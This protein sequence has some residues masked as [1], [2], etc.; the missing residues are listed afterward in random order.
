MLVSAATLAEVGSGF[1]F[2]TCNIICVIW[3]IIAG[4]AA[5]II[6]VSGV[7]FITAETYEK[8]NEA[9]INII[10]AVIGIIIVVIAPYTANYL[11]GGLGILPFSCG[12]L[13]TL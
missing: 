11:T 4:F 8:R 12:C 9:K 1:S 5:L 10:Y 3:Y 7:E 2:I 13:P 6:V